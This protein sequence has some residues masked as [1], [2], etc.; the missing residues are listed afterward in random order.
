MAS[1]GSSKRL[2]CRVTEEEKENKHEMGPRTPTGNGQ[3]LRSLLDMP[4]LILMSITNRIS[5]IPSLSCFAATSRGSRNLTRAVARSSLPPLLL[6][7]FAAPDQVEPR[8]WPRQ[9]KCYLQSLVPGDDHRLILAR[10]NPK[11]RRGCLGSSFGNLILSYGRTI[12][13]ANVFTGRETRVNCDLLKPIHPNVYFRCI[14]TAPLDSPSCFLMTLTLAG[15][16]FCK[17]FNPNGECH[18]LAVPISRDETQSI[19]VLNNKIFFMSLK[20]CLS[21]ADQDYGF[22]MVKMAVSVPSVCIPH[23]LASPNFG[24]HLVECDGN[25]L[26]V[27]FA[28]AGEGSSRIS[29]A[30]AY[31]LEFLPEM[32]WAEVRDLGEWCLLIDALGTCPIACPSPT[33]WGGRNNC[34]YVAGPGHETWSVFPLDGSEIDTADT[35]LDERFH[36]RCRYPSPMWVYP[37]ILYRD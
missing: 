5:S 4:D 7:S 16:I 13:I 6:R 31:R 29:A 15:I 25:L 34:V 8:D 37:S 26:L 18:K 24:R 20:G 1:H 19:A 11:T 21:V 17:P 27:I 10:I 22:S 32:V 23:S 30:H 9:T 3:R 28:T 14:L 33:R 35:P 12:I 2:I 36:E